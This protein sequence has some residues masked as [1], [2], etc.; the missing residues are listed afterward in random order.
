MK[1]CFLKYTPKFKIQNFNKYYEVLLN[2]RRRV[3]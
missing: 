2:N 1:T 3:G